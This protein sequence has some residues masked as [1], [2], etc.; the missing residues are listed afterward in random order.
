MDTWVGGWIDGWM[1]IQT[2]REIG[3]QIVR[4]DR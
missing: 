4:T 1:D 2:R 3:R